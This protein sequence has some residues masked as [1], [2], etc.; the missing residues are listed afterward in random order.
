MIG[1]VTLGTNNLEKAGAFYD[2]LLAQF[3]AERAYTLERMIAWSSDPAKPML[4]LTRPSDGADAAPGNGGMVAL[5]C[6]DADHVRAAHRLAMHLGAKNAGLPDAHGDR[7][8]GGYVRD[9]DG[10]KICLFTMSGDGRDP[11]ANEQHAP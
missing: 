5:I 4:V 9:P 7:F 2:T 8:F 1:Y 11:P 10:N 6:K 3:G